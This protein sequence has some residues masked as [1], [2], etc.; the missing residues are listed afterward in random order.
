MFL[1]LSSCAYSLDNGL[2]LT[3]QMGWNSW[4]HFAC[5]IDEEIITDTIDALASSPLMKAGYEYVN[6][7][8][9]WAVGR[10]SD[11]TIQVDSKQFPNGLASLAEHSHSKGLKFGLYSDAG[12]QT[13][14][15]RPGSLHYEVNDANTYAEWKVDYLKYDNCNTDGSRPEVRYPV[16]RDALNK[17]GRPIFFSMCE[18]GVDDPATWARDVGNSWR[19]TGD[20]QDNWEKMISIA[21]MN[22]KL[23]K[24]AKPGGWNDPDMLEVGNGGMSTTEY[25]AHFSL[26]CLMKAPLLIGCD[27]RNMSADTTRILTNEDAIAV[28]QDPLGIQG[29]KVR[30]EDDLEVWAG[31]LKDGSV[32]AVLLNRGL[33]SA[34]IK[35]AAQDL[36]WEEESSFVVYDIW[37]HKNVGT[38]KGTYSTN[39]ES[40]GVM[41]GRFRPNEDIIDNF[42]NKFM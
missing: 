22:D 35:V 27:L 13:C 12:F 16:M 10:S 25:I 18:W 21:D 3:P 14:A 15:K 1:L 7:D 6:I 23:W 40:H 2:G 41:F 38:F 34:V 36:G 39:V 9:C 19:T 11:G 33:T 4:N 8:D 28:N 42:I 30:A 20:I 32:A 17:T 26:W 5:S 29:H 37:K 24:Y 31:P